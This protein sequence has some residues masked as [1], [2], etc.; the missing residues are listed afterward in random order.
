M[1]WC[2]FKYRENFTSAST[3]IIIQY[4][5]IMNRYP[6]F[7]TCYLH[8]LL[9]NPGLRWGQYQYWSFMGKLR[10]C[11]LLWKRKRWEDKISVACRDIGSEDG[12]VD[13][14]VFGQ[15][16]G[17][18]YQPYITSTLCSR[19]V[20]RASQINKFSYFQRLIWHI[21]GCL[22]YSMSGNNVH[23]ILIPI[24]KLYLSHWKKTLH[25]S[26]ELLL[27]PFMPSIHCVHRDVGS[28]K[29]CCALW[30]LM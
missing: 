13:G 2:L 14:T 12:R 6:H 1:A 20:Q 8:R 17:L 30:C 23:F 25:I 26:H 22:F 28:D 5:L 11:P 3:W 21:A 7:C 4:P 10:K 24:F 16:S 29:F 15:R 18:R 9:M 27:H 19:N